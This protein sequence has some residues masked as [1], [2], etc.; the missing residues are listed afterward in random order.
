MSTKVRQLPLYA[1]YEPARKPAVR[2]L[3]LYV[4]YG[5]TGQ[6]PRGVNGRQGV[7]NMLQEQTEREL[8]ANHISIGVPEVSSL[9]DRNTRVLVTGASEYGINGE[10]YFYYN[11]VPLRSL[12]VPISFSLTGESSVYG[13]LGK[14]ST[15]SETIVQQTDVLDAAVVNN[16]VM[17]TASD[18]SYFFL[19]GTQLELANR[20]L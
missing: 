14:L 5:D 17:M 1:L 20:T 15:A 6:L 8:G 13:L 7:F 12:Y 16:K 9:Y 10:M 2:Q 3:P 4:V 11:R 18:Q 19:P